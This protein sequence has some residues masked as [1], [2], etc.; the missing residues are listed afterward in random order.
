M[1]IP[2]LRLTPRASIQLTAGLI[3]PTMRRATASTRRTGQSRS[4]SHMPPATRTRWIIV[5]GDTSK[6]TTRVFSSAED[7][8]SENGGMSA[9]LGWM[10][11]FTFS[12]AVSLLEAA[13]CRD[14]CAS[15]IVLPPTARSPCTSHARAGATTAGPSTLSSGTTATCASSFRVRSHRTPRCPSRMPPA[16]AARTRAR[17]SPH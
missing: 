2:R 17:E 6:R 12:S 14:R 3:V 13:A 5:A 8:R 10:S 4:S 11:V 15:Q 16:S 1:A 9:V 7:G